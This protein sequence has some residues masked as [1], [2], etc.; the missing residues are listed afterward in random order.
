MMDHYSIKESEKE[1]ERTSERVKK[2]IDRG[3]GRTSKVGR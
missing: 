2:K 3:K 1:R